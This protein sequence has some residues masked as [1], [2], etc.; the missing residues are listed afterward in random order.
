MKGRDAMTIKNK[1]ILITGADGFIG[2][3]LAETLVDKGADVRALVYYN[4]FNSYGNLEG[5][6]CLSGIEVVT[7]DVRDEGLCR[8]MTRGIDIVFNLAAL[9][10]IPYSYRAPKSYMDTN[11]GGTLNICQAALSNNVQKVI[12]IS[13]S[14]VYGTAR[15]VPIGESH[16]LSPQ[17]VYSASKIASD[18]F[19]LSFYHSFGL[20]VTLARPFNTYGPRQSARA[21]IPSVI[22]QI[23]AGYDEIKLGDL[24][25]T[26]DLSYVTDVCRALIMLAEA[27]CPGETVNIGSDYE[28][29]MSDVFN[30]INEI[31]GKNVSA[32]ID[33]AR[34]RPAGSEVF[35]LWC[36]NSKLKALTGFTPE[37]DIRAG[38][39]STIDWFTLPENLKRYK[40]EIYNL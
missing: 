7:G 37:Y 20:P 39:K 33:E 5:L 8:E 34:L 40:T 38:L 17:S 22:I 16:P 24:K 18:A 26:R 1:K 15:C 4:S 35:R 10:A 28:I 9:V 11:A 36:D 29:S 25:P 19:A 2:S 12:Q 13:T 6:P 32:V 31:M 14:E 23:A 27:D 3:H 30:L 21:F